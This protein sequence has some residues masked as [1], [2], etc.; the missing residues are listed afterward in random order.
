VFQRTQTDRVIHPK[1]TQFIHCVA[2]ARDGNLRLDGTAARR[3]TFV[4]RKPLFQTDGTKT[5]ATQKELSIL[6]MLHADTT[7]QKIAHFFMTDGEVNNFSNNVVR[8]EIA[9]FFFFDLVTRAKIFFLQSCD[10]R[11]NLFSSIL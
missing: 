9:E 5:M 2:N 4:A 11:R 3:A 1:A 10:T 7:L 6:E 8:A